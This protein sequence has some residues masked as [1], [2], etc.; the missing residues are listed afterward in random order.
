L[1]ECIRLAPEQ[2]WWLHRRWKDKRELHRDHLKR[3][4][5]FK[6]ARGH[7]K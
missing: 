5:F 6:E 7:F 1:E 2:Y 4:L 3:F